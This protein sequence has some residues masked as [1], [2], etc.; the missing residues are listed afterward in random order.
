MAKYS[1]ES[2]TIG[3]VIET[4]VL[5]EMFYELVPEARDYEDIIEMGKGFTIEQALP[6]IENIAD[7]LGITN[8][9]ERIDDFKAKLE[10]IE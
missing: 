1:F 9:Q 5:A 8:T 7:S 10:A 2:T 4:P 6:F 3:E